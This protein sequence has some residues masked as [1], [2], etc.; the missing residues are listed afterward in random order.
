MNLDQFNLNPGPGAKLFA[1]GSDEVG[2]F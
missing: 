2:N 1:K